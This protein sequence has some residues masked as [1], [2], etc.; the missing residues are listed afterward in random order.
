MKAGEKDSDHQFLVLE[1]DKDETC[2]SF[3]TQQN[4]ASSQA[5][6][7]AQFENDRKIVLE[8]LQNENRLIRPRRTGKWLYEFGRS[9]NN[10]RGLWQRLPANEAV[11]HNANWEVVFDLDAFC[12]SEDHVWVW[13]GAIPAFFDPDRV[14]LVLSDGGS[15]RVRFIEFDCNRKCIVE[16]GFDIAPSKA[17]VSWLDTDTIILSSS[18][19]EGDA[20]K[21]GWPGAIRR[22]KRGDDPLIAPVILR[23]N[24]SDV[25][26]NGTAL[27]RP[28]D[29]PLIA[30]TTYHELQKSSVTLLNYG[31][32]PVLLNAPA[33]A[34]VSC[35]QTH[36]FYFT[37]SK[38]AYPTGSLILNSFKNNNSSYEQHR[39]VFI[40]EDRC[41][42]DQFLLLDR[43]LAWTVL[44]NLKPSLFILALDDIEAKPFE[45]SLPEGSER[46]EISAL[47]M[48]VQLDCNILLV[49]TQGFLNAPVIYQLD[50]GRYDGDA[51]LEE[52]TRSPERFD[53]EGMTTRLLE[54]CSDD[55]T[56]VPYHIVLPV[57]HEQ[58]MG[59][60]PI[61]MCG[62]GGYEIS[63][64][65]LY[66]F[67]T[68]KL[69]LERGGAYV[70]AHIRGG[71]EFGPDW[72]QAAMRENRS[73]SFEDFA[74]IAKDLV[75]RGFTTS[76]KIACTGGSNGGLLVGVMLTRYPELFGAIWS[77]VPVMD[78]LRFHKF[79][80]GQAWIEEYGDPEKE[81]DRQF[82][83]AYS[84]LHNVKSRSDCSY[85]PTYIE[86]N[87]NDDRV[88]PS[89]ARRMTAVLLEA[90]QE[91]LFHEFGSGGH[92][93]VGATNEEAVRWA[94]AFRF[95]RSVLMDG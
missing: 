90:K 42:L 33:E 2:Q 73:R 48:E 93:S 10:P 89:H 28:D 70:L 72:H 77:S 54:A 56:K 7:D 83:Q 32:E 84:P 14:L 4:E 22:V 85:P 82:L 53:A 79:A 19:S 41:A 87:S 80:A 36:Y 31:S 61:L 5:L 18:A 26:V 20:T 8:L 95:L 44:D 39:A 59:Q 9:G 66:G 78:M 91:V 40:P 50:L 81:E 27:Q 68:G 30:I 1:D 11:T 65:P 52:L 57:N 35:N 13:F 25:L 69:W 43:W 3:V 86:S 15:D 92:G 24:S 46:V 58:E 63:L 64:K 75:K 6:C 17:D 60:L 47:D 71:G 29:V 37:R 62:Y 74:A 38:G 94:M 67:V 88:H 16:N 49:Y 45:I 23:A 55:G 76:N 51:E 21:S 34:H 12:K